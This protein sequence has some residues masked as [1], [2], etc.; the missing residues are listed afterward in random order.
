MTMPMKNVASEVL[1]MGRSLRQ[2][3]FRRDERALP[4]GG[5]PP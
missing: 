4:E 5:E 1:F 3:A 2:A